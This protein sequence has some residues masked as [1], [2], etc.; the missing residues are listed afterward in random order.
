M[1]CDNYSFIICITFNYTPTLQQ[2]GQQLMMD[3]NI[4]WNLT[5][6][7]WTINT[8]ADSCCH[9]NRTI[10][11][12]GVGYNCHPLI[13]TLEHWLQLNTDF[14]LSIHTSNWTQTWNWACRLETEHAD[15]KLSMQTS[16]WPCRLQT[17]HAD[18]KLSMQTS[19]WA[20]RLQ[21][22][23]ADL[24]LGMQ[25]SNWTPRQFESIE[26]S[27]E[28]GFEPFSLIT[29]SL[30]HRYIETLPYVMVMSGDKQ[31]HLTSEQQNQN[32]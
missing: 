31:R 22:E 9:D 10:F 1:K 4:L 20:C 27:C 13:K 6:L 28:V 2:T 18:F 32:T 19:N 24:K 26:P 5:Y 23:H 25:T 17:E 12:K 7:T 8:T 16:N 11:G 29:C 30:V 21:I 14:K 3:S 15:L